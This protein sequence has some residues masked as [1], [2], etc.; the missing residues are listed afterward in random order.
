MKFVT[1]SVF[2]IVKLTPAPNDPITE[3]KTKD[4]PPLIVIDREAE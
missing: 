2:N 4:H 1:H 3:W